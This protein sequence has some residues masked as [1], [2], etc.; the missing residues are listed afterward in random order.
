MDTKIGDWTA[1][2]AT[3]LAD[4]Q[5]RFRIWA[6]GVQELE[7]V[8]D[9]GAVE[10][11]MQ[12]TG[13]GWFEVTTAKAG[14]G[15]RYQYKV[16]NGLWVPDPASRCQS[17]DAHGPSVVVDPL[18]YDWREDDWRGR[19]WHETALVELHVGTATPEGTLAGLQRR[20]DHYVSSGITAIELMPLADFPGARGWGYDGVLPFAPDRAY[21]GPDDLHALIDAAHAR[22]LMVFLDV[23]YNHFGPDGNYLHVYAPQFFTDRFHTPW[24]S[25][26]DFSQRPV[27][28]FFIANAVYW[29]EAF[30]FDG[31]RFDAVHAIRDDSPTHILTELAETVY[32]RLPADRHVHLVLENDANE[33][34][35]LT[36]QSGG[37]ADAYTAQWNDDY[38]HVLHVLL[39][40]ELD[41]YYED[42]ER[43]V[44]QLA[45]AL[46]TGYVYQGDASRHRGGEARG[47]P[48]RHLPPTAFVN[49]IQN[50]D[51]IGN[52]AFGDRLTTLA[53]PEAVD[54][55]LALLLLAPQIPML[56]M[57]EEW[58]ATEPFLYFCDFHDE[59]ADAVREGRRKEFGKF[60][61]FAD[62][63]ARARIPDPNAEDTFANSRLVW[64]DLA[65]GSPA[66]AR[67]RLDLVARLLRLRAQYV[68][69]LL[70]KLTGGSAAAERILDAGLRVTWTADDGSRL[71]LVC[72][73]SDNP[74]EAVA[75]F[76]PDRTPLFAVPEAAAIADRAL[77]AWSV[78]WTLVAPE[79]GADG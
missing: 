77:P 19:P 39:T 27:R 60:G 13:D 51:Q 34:R 45:T 24:G 67:Q 23:V 37:D 47:E 28:D 68:A 11:A 10:L 66:G 3:P 18:A 50:H 6:P 64:P 15:T 56:Y 73:L 17:D 58:G 53:R 21:G 38:H 63:A 75:V 42:Y 7:L 41:G 4:G 2:G 26:I 31:L 40:G 69:P 16:P 20:L 22:G 9:A 59:L 44:D 36:H 35:F 29:L 33:A 70:P 5:V 25:A 74:L 62:P 12:P 49:F 48:S 14:I 65:A 61:Q 8:L 54:A 52:R 76:D 1:F 43:P 78:V 57:G 72:N 71:V 55:A 46:T 30:R 79:P 32:R